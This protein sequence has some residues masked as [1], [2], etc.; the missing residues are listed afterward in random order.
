[1]I[2]NNRTQGSRQPSHL[3][4]G[5]IRSKE[6]MLIDDTGDKKGIVNTKEAISLAYGKGLDLVCVAAQ[7]KPPVCKIMDF[8]K[9]KFEMQKKQRQAK[10]NQITSQVKEIR[11]SPTIDIG[12]FNTK[13]KK[14]LKFL[15]TG[16]KLKLS[17]RFRGRMIVHKELG[18]EVLKKF[19][20]ECKEIA[21]VTQT[22]KMDGRSMFMLLEPIKK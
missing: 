12:D 15:E 16:N 9:Y 10:K 1:M 19:R 2:I 4:N 13:L 22:P 11:L 14:G 20:D 7:A 3:I 6:I 18:Y 5:A 17:I 21:L 8:Q